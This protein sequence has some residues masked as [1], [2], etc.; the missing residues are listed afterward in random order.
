MYIDAVAEYEQWPG[1][2]GRE[3]YNCRQDFTYPVIIDR[4]S[5]WYPE[6][7]ACVNDEAWTEEDDNSWTEMKSWN[8]FDEW[9]D[10][11]ENSLEEDNILK[12]D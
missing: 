10:Y 6:Y 9:I 12:D 7:W 1:E 8:S 5:L 4:G 11:I 2:T 3:D